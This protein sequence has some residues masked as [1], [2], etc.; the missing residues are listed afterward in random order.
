MRK[1]YQ[2]VFIV[3]DHFCKPA[4]KGYWVGP[5]IYVAKSS[6]NLKCGQYDM[7]FQSVPW[8]CPAHRTCCWCYPSR[9]TPRY[10]PLRLLSGTP[11]LGRFIFQ[12]DLTSLLF[13]YPVR[14][15]LEQVLSRHLYRSLHRPP[16]V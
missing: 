12:S 5:N 1:A 13:T 11:C 16:D 9:L 7:N 3:M 10:S 15:Q 6:T 2:Q 14:K 8:R 4:E